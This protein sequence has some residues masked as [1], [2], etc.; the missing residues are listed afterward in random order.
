MHI[1]DPLRDWADIRL[2]LAIREAGSLVGAAAQLELTQPTVGRRLAAMEQ[3]FGTPLFVRAGRRMQLTDAGEAILDSARRMEREMYAIERSLEAQSTAL[4][5]EVVVSATE[6]TGT[7][8]LT[9]V[10]KDFHGEYPEILVTVQIDNRAVDLVHREADIAIRLGQPAQDNVIARKLLTVG[11]GLYA[12]P[13]YLA[14][15]PPVERLEDLAEHKLVGL[16]AAGTDLRSPIAFPQANPLP[17]QYVYLT[18]SP[19]A[20]LSAVRAGFGIGLISHRWAT[21][22]GDLVRL[23]PDYTP[24]A[25][26][27]WLVTHEDLRYSARIRVI[28][29][30]LA[31]RIVRDQALFE[32]GLPPGD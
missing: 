26:D 24:H 25:L 2:F 9:P 20:Q 29:D 4:R 13:G 30:F 31:E 28:Y 5:G 21:M 3:R 17:G 32:S 23:L 15:T 7:D 22:Q 8:W 6:G 10:L 14:G 16:D 27:L 19:A 1:K 11:F 12:T 18:N